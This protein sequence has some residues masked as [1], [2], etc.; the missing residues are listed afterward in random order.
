MDYEKAYKDAVSKIKLI[1]ADKKKQG[2]TN[3]LFEGD[4]NEIFPELKESEDEKTRKELMGFVVIN[5]ISNDQ[6]RIK[7][8]R[9]LEKQGEQN[10][11]WNEEDEKILGKCIDAASG[12]YSPED[13]QSM[14]DWLKSLKE[15]IKRE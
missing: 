15:R 2:L 3:C 6:R 1:I 13:K 4:L 14:K 12:Y 9:W 11:A 8:L 5:T 7:Y 10:P